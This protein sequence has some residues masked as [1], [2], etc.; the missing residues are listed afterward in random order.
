MDILSDKVVITRKKHK[1]SACGRLFDKGTKMRTQVN[2]SDGIITWRECPTCQKLLDK[3]RS[4]FENHD[5]T[6][7]EFCVCDMLNNDQTPEDFLRKLE[8]E[9]DENERT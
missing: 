7:Y 9:I 3:F 6:C 2:T 8:K 4:H 5:H 1:C